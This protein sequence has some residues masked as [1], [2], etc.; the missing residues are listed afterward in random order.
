VHGDAA[1]LASKQSPCHSL[2]GANELRWCGTAACNLRVILT[3]G[4]RTEGRYAYSYFWTDL[5][6]ITFIYRSV[7]YT[8]NVETSNSHWR[9]STELPTP[10]SH[11]AYSSLHIFPITHIFLRH[12]SHYAHFPLCTFSITHISHYAYTSLRTFPIMHI[13][14]ITRITH[15]EYFRLM[16][17]QSHRSNCVIENSRINFPFFIIRIP[18]KQHLS[19]LAAS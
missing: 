10:V 2:V 3:N 1:R 19:P 7:Y 13:C 17:F 16:Y 8:V 6:F 12:I 5:S 15:H 18:F 9:C 11:Y 14:P 4:Y